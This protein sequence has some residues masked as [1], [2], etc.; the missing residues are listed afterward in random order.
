MAAVIGVALLC[1]GAA[2]GVLAVSLPLPDSL[3]DAAPVESFPVSQ[4][5]FTDER[6][7]GVAVEFGPDRELTAPRDG[8]ITAARCED[9]GELTSGTAPFHIDGRPVLALATGT[10]LWRTLSAG[11]TGADVLALET[12]LARLGAELDPDDRFTSTTLTAF[13]DLIADVGGNPREV[14]AVSPEQIAWLPAETILVTGCPVAIGA[15]VGAGDTL[16]ALPSLVLGAAVSPMPDGLL[17]ADRIVRIDDQSFAV[18][19]TGALDASDLDR[20]ATTTSFW[21]VRQF[22][23]DE[24]IRGQ[25]VM[26]EPISAYAIPPRA[27]VDSGAG[28]CVVDD[29]GTATH[30]EVLASE[31]GQTFV[32]PTDD[33]AMLTQVRLDPPADLTCG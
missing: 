24:P 28:L 29:D 8:V 31:L 21:A 11:D 33:A 16:A 12:E 20:L 5:E 4:V 13:R 17:E 22:S 27:I 15:Q 14:T 7:V 1:V 32:Q 19:D 3:D 25:L 10:P 18:D 26:S 23:V 9:G 6:S 30:V 2:A